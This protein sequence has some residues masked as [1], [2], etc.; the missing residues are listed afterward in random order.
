MIAA[1]QDGVLESVE[2]ELFRFGRTVDGDRALRDALADR[3]GTPQAKADLISALLRGK[4]AAATVHLARQAVLAPRG[5]RLDQSLD[6]YLAEAAARR[7]Q[8][9]A[10]ATVASAL[11]QAQHDRLVA[12]LSALFGRPVQLN[13]DVDPAIVGG[14]RVEVGDEIIDG[15]IEGRLEEAR[16]RLAG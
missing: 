4:A 16:R 14:I 2:D 9:I 3:R 10:H 6:L 8:T 1:E 5:R 7:E 12:A 15:S 11:S 13:V